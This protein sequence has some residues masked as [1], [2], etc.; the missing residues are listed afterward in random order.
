[1]PNTLKVTFKASIDR[2]ESFAL[3]MQHLDK[4]GK[5][6]TLTVKLDFDNTVTGE[7]LHERVLD[8]TAGCSVNPHYDPNPFDDPTMYGDREAADF[9]T[10][11]DADYDRVREYLSDRL[12]REVNVTILRET[13][14]HLVN[15]ESISAIKYI[16]EQLRLSLHSSKAIV[17]AIKVWRKTIRQRKD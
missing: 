5:L 15:C 11:V 2:L 14:R 17:D 3:I 10:F 7:G 9:A 1:M 8:A 13:V 4:L 16:R 6:G 12:N